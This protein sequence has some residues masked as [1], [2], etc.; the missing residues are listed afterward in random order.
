MRNKTNPM[1]SL[2]SLIPL[3]ALLA[4]AAPGQQVRYE[5]DHLTPV[6]A[7]TPAWRTKYEKVL[8]PQLRLDATYVVRMVVYP[9]FSGEISVRLHGPEGETDLSKISKPMLTCY[10]AD[11]SIWDAMPGSSNDGKQGQVIVSMT[12][13][14]VSKPFALRLQTLWDEMLKRTNPPEKPNTML[15]GTTFKFTTPGQ[16]GE[17]S[18]PMRRLSPLLFTELGWS[19]IEL[20]EADPKNPQGKAVNAALHAKILEDYLKAHPAD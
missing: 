17:A 20:C 1:K 11:N 13:I 3:V 2:L 7:E 14:E 15:D 18:N 12:S 19:L 8:R 9:S 5:P 6:D 16:A 10:R 4:S